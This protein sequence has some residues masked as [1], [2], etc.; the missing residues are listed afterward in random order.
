MKLHRHLFIYGSILIAPAYLG[1]MAGQFTAYYRSTEGAWAGELALAFL[2]AAAVAFGWDR[3]CQTP[4]AFWVKK[5]SS[6]TVLA[7][8]IT[9]IEWD[10]DDTATVIC[11]A[12]DGTDHDI[13]LKVGGAVNVRLTQP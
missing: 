10:D 3:L 2:L 13:R 9:A 7:A 8:S 1:L 6:P 11:R 4:L 12:A 5:K